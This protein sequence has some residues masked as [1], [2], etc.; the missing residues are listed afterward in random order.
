MSMSVYKKVTIF[1]Q[2]LWNI[3]WLRKCI[4]ATVSSIRPSKRTHFGFAF[5]YL[6]VFCSNNFGIGVNKNGIYIKKK[7]FN[8]SLKLKFGGQC[9][10]KL[11][12]YFYICYNMW[13]VEGNYLC[14]RLLVSM[15]CWEM[16]TNIKLGL[17]FWHWFE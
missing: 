14:Q 1:V 11:F 3:G 2:L 10:M 16:E 15:K 4:S 5:K 12:N 17:M 7:F 8:H 9:V 13:Y 6:C